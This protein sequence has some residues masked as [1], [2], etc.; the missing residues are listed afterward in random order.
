MKE[1]LAANFVD[2]K[3]CVEK[4]ELMEKVRRLYRDRKQAQMKGNFIPL[5]IFSPSHF[6]SAQELGDS[7]A[8]ESEQCKICMDALV[9]C[10]FLDCGHMV[11]HN[12]KEK[13]QH[14]FS[15]FF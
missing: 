10:V 9:D 5:F 2:F 14:S 6:S 3:G 1:I 11:S 13:S 4:S 7:P 8:I 15:P 12:R